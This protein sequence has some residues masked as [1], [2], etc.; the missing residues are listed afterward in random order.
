MTQLLNKKI[1]AGEKSLK[2]ISDEYDVPIKS[3]RRWL[4]VGHERKKGGGRK[5]RDLE[6][7][8]KLLV[9]YKEEREKEG[10]LIT[11]KDIK[12]KALEFS[13]NNDFNASKGWLEKMRMRFDLHIDPI[14]KKRREKLKESKS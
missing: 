3:I 5:I 10:V 2:E 1:N 9:W 8:D 13:T 4:N 7:V 12:K 6:M 11:S 14:H